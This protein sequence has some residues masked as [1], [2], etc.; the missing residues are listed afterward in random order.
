MEID[1]KE[2]LGFSLMQLNLLL[3]QIVKWVHM[4]ASFTITFS[5][6]VNDNAFLYIDL[7]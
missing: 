2:N 3:G 1:E 7:L 5:F 6:R 4:S